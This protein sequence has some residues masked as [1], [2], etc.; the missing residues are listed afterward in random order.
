[1]IYTGIM[2]MKILHVFKH[3]KKLCKIWHNEFYVDTYL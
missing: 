3:L 2:H 1:M